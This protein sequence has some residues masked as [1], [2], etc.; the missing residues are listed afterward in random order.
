MKAE[1]TLFG[2]PAEKKPID[3]SQKFVGV[4]ASKGWL[5][6]SLRIQKCRPAHRLNLAHTIGCVVSLMGISN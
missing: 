1:D 3:L 6:Q 4:F 2:D 5:N